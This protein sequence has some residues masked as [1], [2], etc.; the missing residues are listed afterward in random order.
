MGVVVEIRETSRFSNLRDIDSVLD[1]MFHWKREDIQLLR[2]FAEYYFVSLATAFFSLQ[3]GIVRHPKNIDVMNKDFVSPAQVS[4]FSI[5]NIQ[6]MTQSIFS[7]KKKNVL[8]R[9]ENEC[10]ASILYR[11]LFEKDRTGHMLIIVPEQQVVDRLQ[12]FFADSVTALP[13]HLSPSQWMSIVTALSQKKRMVCIGTRKAIQLPLSKFHRIIV[14]DE[15]SKS[16]QQYD[17]NPRYHARR[18]IQEYA[19][20]LDSCPTLFSS[21]APSMYAMREVVDGKREF[22]SL[23]GDVAFSEIV[24]ME[25]EYAA[26]NYSWLSYTLRERI[27]DS[28]KKS[29]LFLN[30][31]GHFSAAVCIECSA[32]LAADATQCTDCQNVNIRRFQRGTAEIAKNVQD[33]LLEANISIP[34]VLVD[35]TQDAVIPH[36]PHILVG[37]E[38]AFRNVRL[39]DYDTVGVLSVDHLLVYPDYRAQ[40]R[41]FQLLSYFRAT[42]RYLLVQ[43]HSPQHDVILGALRGD[44]LSF[45]DKELSSRLALSLPPYV[46]RFIVRNSRGVSGQ[47][48][49][50]VDLKTLPKNATVER[51]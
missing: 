20:F 28:E 51:Q 24:D 48:Q 2:W 50:S 31:T 32:L 49:R 46:D 17:A 10:M 36:G 13:A 34:V 9:Y 43:T 26:G 16:L 27:L 38:K 45:A 11:L 3:H 18:V 42:A 14:H 21:V 25:K 5:E 6:K 37:T 4:T 35:S 39:S 29:F 8:L 33:A 19:V 22:Y 44:Y 1:T 12:M 23:S 40:E 41:V 47:I 15:E 7:H 30:R